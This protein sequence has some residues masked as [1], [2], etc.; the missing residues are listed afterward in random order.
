MPIVHDSIMDIHNWIMDT[1]YWIVLF[2]KKFSPNS[3]QPEHCK[4]THE[5]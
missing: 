4:L 3:E 1:P 2:H 5:L